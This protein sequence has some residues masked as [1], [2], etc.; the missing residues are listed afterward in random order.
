MAFHIGGGALIAVLLA[1]TSIA[2]S[3]EATSDDVTL[4]ERLVVTAAGG[5]IDIRT[6]PAS[7]SVIS[8]EDIEQSSGQSLEQL[9]ATVPGVNIS[10]SGNLQY[11]QIRGLP[12]KYSLFLIDG[13][14][15][16]SDPNLFRG[17]DF[18]AAWIPLASI[19]R[20]EVVRG[21]MSSLYG[22][23][24]I[25]GVVNII[26]KK[27]DG[28]LHGSL[29]QE[30]TIQENRKSGDYFRTSGFI[31]GPIVDDVLSFRLSGSWDH[32]NADADDVNAP[33]VDW[34]GDFLTGFLESENRHLDGNLQWTPDA[35]NTVDID[36]SYAYRMHDTIPIDRNALSITHTGTYDFG[37]TELRLSAD[38]I[39][40]HQGHNNATEYDANPNTAYN[41]NADGRVV[42][43]WDA[44]LDQTITLGAALN[45]Q[46]VEDG[47]ALA[48]GGTSDVWQGAVYL[49]DRFQLTDQL[50][51]TLGNRADYH[52]DFGLHNSPKAFLVYELTDTLTIKSGISASFKAPTLLQSSSNWLNISCGGGC[53]IAGSSDLEPETGISGEFGL[54]YDDGTWQWGLTYFQNQ[55]SNVITQSP[56]RT[57]D[58]AV[59]STYSNYVG[60]SSDGMPI[61]SYY[62]S[63]SLRSNGIEANVQFSPNETWTFTGG[64]TYVNS[65]TTND[66]VE[67]ATTYQPTHVANLGAIWQATEQL[68]LG[69]DIAFVSEQ[70]TSVNS[71][72]GATESTA[73]GYAELNLT[74]RYAVNDNLDL[75]GGIMNVLDA[76]VFRVDD[77][78]FN[79]DGR[80]FY[81]SATAKF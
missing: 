57:S 12:S 52:A 72:K 10:H 34:S 54:N 51:L 1:S 70:V 15:V 58:A 69:A 19:E 46:R 63:D 64:Y 71:S 47:Y 37:D 6:A 79:V 26:T 9:L 28:Q 50:S 13:K 81:I 8:S 41:L 40:N 30:V 56:T 38:R 68:N 36:Y 73:P 77:N 35:Q 39:Y 23:D 20:I 14:R 18:D 53:Y 43:P 21:A 29:T 74:A 33:N 5:T 25:G 7:I 78:D 45:Y 31:S 65:T 80:R 16:N 67:S 22:S 4:L 27:S 17:N 61:Y 59:G 42:F 44:F 3:Q 48:D 11:V 55:L 75:S 49:E 60:L 2:Y 66:G 32:R 76:Q 62:N 24:A